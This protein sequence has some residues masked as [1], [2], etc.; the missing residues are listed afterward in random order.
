M[1]TAAI[2]RY[3]AAVAPQ[4]DLYEFGVHGL[5]RVG[6]PVVSASLWAQ[7]GS[8]GVHGA[9]YGTSEEEAARGG[10]GELVE[11]RAAH[12]VVPLL[13]RERASYAGLCAELGSSAVLDPRHGSLPAG[14]PYTDRMELLWVP[15]RRWP[16]GEEV[17]VPLEFAA[18]CHADLA[19]IEPPSGEWL[20]VPITN[21]QGAGD[22]VE[23]ALS[24]GILELLQRDG[25]S[26]NYRALDRGVVVDVD[27]TADRDL[28]G[29]LQ[30][31]DDAGIDVLVKLAATDFGM[32][33]VYVVGRERDP[34]AAGHPLMVTSCG[35][36]VHPDRERA[37]RKA[38]L[39]YASSRARKAFSHMA[40]DQLHG[41]APDG[42]VEHAAAEQ[43]FVEESRSLDAMLD[44]LRRSPAELQ[45]LMAPRFH[46]ERHR[47][48]L[49]G[50]PTTPNPQDPSALLDL[51]V[52]RLDGMEVLWV[53]FTAGAGPGCRSL[54]AIVPGLE[55]E[56][57]TYHRCGERNLRRLEPRG[58]AGRGDV[59]PGAKPLPAVRGAWL[60]TDRIDA[61][62]GELYPLYREPDRHVAGKVLAGR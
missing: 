6:I 55:V 31:F 42:Y 53:D 51:L 15:A 17:W 28:R 25:N 59:P 60:A 20:V 47:V 34:D 41:I 16:E 36:A 22:T 18:T 13:P 21:G 37:V 2:D 10:L 56:T 3:R 29:L 57:A 52:E 30:R 62:V 38:L 27:E 43:L 61:L 12:V 48:P 5:D 14:S 50:L 49:S 23:R 9:G 19:G 33:N 39:E 46:S 4:G 11:S 58:L 44:W 26:V 7:D 1:T 45:E 24:H 35:E 8:G 32:A 40:L 54:K